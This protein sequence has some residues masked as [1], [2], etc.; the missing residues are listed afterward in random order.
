[1]TVKLILISALNDGR[2]EAW[3]CQKLSWLLPAM[4]ASF[5]G[6]GK[7]GNISSAAKRDE[8]LTRAREKHCVTD[9]L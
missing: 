8:T 3:T 9:Q 1:M 2:S 7:V 5:L 4:L 6:R